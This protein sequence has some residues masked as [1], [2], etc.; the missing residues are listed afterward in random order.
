MHIA[1][2]AHLLSFGQS[3]RAAGISRYIAGLVRGLQDADS[4]DSFTVYLGRQRIPDGFVT[5]SNLRLAPSR[6]AT[7]R[8]WVRVLWEQ[9]IQP[10]ALA[11]D[12]PDLLHSLAFVSPVLW[13][14]RTVLTIY[15]LSFLLYP[16]R[17]KAANRVY[18]S[19]MTR[20]SSRR[21]RY[22]VAISQRTKADVVRMLGVAAERVEVVPPALEPDFRPPAPEA[23]AEFRRR[24]GLPDHFL[25]YVGTLEPRKNL[26]VLVR[27]FKELHRH[28][29]DL[30]L[31]LAGGKG[32]GYQEVQREIEQAWL[33]NAVL[34]P[35]F[36]PSG[37]LPLWYA[38][39]DVFVYP[40]LYEGFG[41]PVL[42]ALACGAPVVC[43]NVS[44]LPEAAGDAALQIDPAD[45]EALAAA[46]TRLRSDA[47][48]RAD[49]RQR[50][51]THAAQFTQ[52]EMGRRMVALYRRAVSAD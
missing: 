17:F 19:T 1:L 28:D 13:A 6:L 30:H 50:G 36:I 45:A 40:S 24:R 42:E 12:R 51:L 34:L 2:N 35:G 52:L 25:L 37:E 5:G 41:L 48:L 8:P 29:S 9:A 11:A 15:D 27:A 18:L 4:Q 32:W 49:L 38:A 39:A 23:V 47:G 3:Y 16:G 21:A 22:V 20:V 33:Q 26:V 14:G 31:V 46:V 44:S 7:D 43:S 10:W